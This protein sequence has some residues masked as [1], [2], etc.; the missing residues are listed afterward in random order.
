MCGRYS[1]IKPVE[2]LSKRFKVQLDEPLKPHYNAAPGQTMPVIT[3]KRPTHFSMFHWGLIPNWSLD[4]KI[5]PNL[6]NA[7]AETI[8]TK[9]PFKQG[10]K[11][12]R[13]LIPADGFYEWKKQGKEKVP[14]R[15]TLADDE[16][17]SF[18]GIWDS[19]EDEK[20]EIINSFTIITTTP[21]ELMLDIHQRMPVILPKE[22]EQK[23]LN[24]NI[25]DQEIVSLLKPYDSSMMYA[26]KTHKSVNSAS[27]DHPECIQPAPKFYPGETLNLFE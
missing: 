25:T 18:A 8:L 21:N 3:N 16:A 4:S 6:I 14:Y 26:Y 20:G 17:F 11:T 22:A 19:W 10:I 5:S 2:Q 24:D 13:C 9:S 27:F 1:L 23:W 12:H 15:I 7:R